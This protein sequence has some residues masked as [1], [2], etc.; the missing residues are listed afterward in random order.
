MNLFLRAKHWHIFVIIFVIPQ[1]LQ[2]VWM[3]LVFNN[4]GNLEETS[5]DDSMRVF[6]EFLSFM[7]WFM[8]VT[9]IISFVQFGWYISVAQGLRAYTP[10][11]VRLNQAPFWIALI[12]IV[13]L[14]LAMFGG[15]IYAIQDIE[16]LVTWLRPE[17]IIPFIGVALLLTIAMLYVL[18]YTAKAYKTALL[19][20]KVERIEVVGEFFM[21]WILFV[22][23]WMMQPNINEMIQREENPPLASEENTDFNQYSN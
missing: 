7:P 3:N 18:Y 19:K 20:R 16:R 2:V 1:L 10:E 14:M 13:V 23:I 5:G 12:P 11:A 4:I 22:G 15:M 9:A 6:N 21:A 8:L 17:Y